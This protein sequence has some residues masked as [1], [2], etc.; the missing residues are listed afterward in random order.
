MTHVELAPVPVKPLAKRADGFEI[1][2]EAEG[3]LEGRDRD[4]GLKCSGVRSRSVGARS[5]CAH[6]G[7]EER[8]GEGK[9]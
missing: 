8:G 5:K 9:G 3:A 6:Y 7:A 2:G 1:A 4:R